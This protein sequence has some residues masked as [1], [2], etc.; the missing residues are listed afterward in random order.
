MQHILSSLLLLHGGRIGGKDGACIKGEL[1]LALAPVTHH[2]KTTR[3]T[4]DMV[5][6]LVYPEVDLHR[7]VRR[8]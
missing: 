3:C 4:V 2:V 6:A 7:T 8:R 5:H 1:A